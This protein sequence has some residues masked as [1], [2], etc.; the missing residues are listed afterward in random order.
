M[1]ILCFYSFR[2]ILILI[3]RLHEE[4]LSG[5]GI[6]IVTWIVIWIT[7]Q[8]MHPIYNKERHDCVNFSA[9]V[10]WSRN[11]NPSNIWIKINPD[12]VFTWNKIS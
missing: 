1:N 6:Q 5:F 9:I 4:K 12:Q 11:C 8:K 7:I 2:E 3:P 10:G